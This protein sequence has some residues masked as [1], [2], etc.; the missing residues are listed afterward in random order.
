MTIKPVQ[1][2]LD[3]YVLNGGGFNGESYIHK[4]DPS[5][6]LKLYFPGKIQQPL[7][8]MILAKKVYDLG[9]PTPEP[10]EHV[11]TEDGRY[12]IRFK[13]IVG[14]TSYSRAVGDNPENVGKY[15]EEF[16]GMC[17]QLHSIH[18]NINEFENVKDRYLRLLKENPFFT[19]AQK[20]RIERFILDT[21]DEDT[22]IHGDLQFSNA[23][24]VGD[25][26]YFIDLG[27]F[28]YGNHLFDVGMVYLCC[29]LSK[30]D[31]IKETF[32]MSKP[33]AK[34]FWDAFAPIY[35]GNDLSLKEIEEMILPYAGLK[36]LIVERDSNCPMPEFRAALKSVL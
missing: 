20:D 11:V 7:D 25:K 21:S 30:E 29:Y 14:K 12:G 28:C 10:G 13:R 8:E 24:F 34:K 27:D 15:A 18:V 35:F 26:R 33:V 3:D 2:S 36:T 23:I 4:T 31:F 1:I 9:I 16:A 22:A 5:V 17:L 32:H 6:M 19:P